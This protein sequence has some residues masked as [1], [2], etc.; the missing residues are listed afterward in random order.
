MLRDVES[1]VCGLNVEEFKDLCRLLVSIALKGECKIYK[2]SNLSMS[3]WEYEAPTTRGPPDCPE[4]LRTFDGR[5]F[6]KGELARLLFRQR[7]NPGYVLWRTL[8]R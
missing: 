6:Q 3:A 8:L 1:G 7:F 5:A 2:E 4:L